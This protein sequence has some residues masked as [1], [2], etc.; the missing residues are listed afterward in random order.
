[1]DELGLFL[2]FLKASALSVGGLAS[3]PLLRAGLVPAF[4]TDAQIVQALAI[5]RLS[6]GPNGL[7]LVSLGYLV[8]GWPGAFVAFVAACLA[9]LVILPAT[10]LARGWLLSAWFAGLV[11]GVALASAGLL[12]GTAIIIAVTA[13][14]AP[15]Q[16][17]LAAG[18]TFLT[19]R[20][21]I[22]PAVM[23]CLGAVAGLAFGR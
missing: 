5:G 3:L 1:M 7:Y 16:L 14:T 8:N 13:G 9:P 19:V 22:H 12:A 6:P 17:V 20:G 15:W 21:R 11:R 2:V 23:V 4:A 10:T 18:A